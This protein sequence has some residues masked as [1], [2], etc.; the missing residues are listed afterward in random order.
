MNKLSA[1]GDTKAARILKIIGEEEISHG[2]T[3]IRWFHHICISRELEPASI[4]QMLVK[5]QFAGFLKPS[6]A[7][8]ARTLAGFPRF[9]CEPLSKLL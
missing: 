2:A 4:F 7:T 5:S 9:Y 1:T 8:N 6:F 3:G